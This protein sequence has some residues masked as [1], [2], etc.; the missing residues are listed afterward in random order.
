MIGYIQDDAPATSVINKSSSPP[1]VTPEQ[2][3]MTVIGTL[4]EIGTRQLRKTPLILTFCP[5]ASCNN[6]DHQRDR[7]EEEYV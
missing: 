2:C 5:N 4:H 6:S 3:T 7:P 1:E